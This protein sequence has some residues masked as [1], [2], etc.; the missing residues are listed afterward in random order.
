MPALLD[1]PPRWRDFDDLSRAEARRVGRY[2]NLVGQLREGKVTPATFRRQVSSWRPIRG[3]RF[4]VDP[5]AVLAILE[6]R[7]SE[8]NE[9]FY[10]HRGRRP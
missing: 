9:P 6:V 4:L 3:Q 10:Y 7:R 8:D 1:D 2:Q 5:D